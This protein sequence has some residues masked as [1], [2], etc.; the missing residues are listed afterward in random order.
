MTTTTNLPF[1]VLSREF[2]ESSKEDLGPF[3]GEWITWDGSLEQPPDVK[4]IDVKLRNGIHL[5]GVFASMIRWSNKHSDGDV[6]AYR[7]SRC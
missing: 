3:L 6:I 1:L 4:L 7:I 5:D 2:A